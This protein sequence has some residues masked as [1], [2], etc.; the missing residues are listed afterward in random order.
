MNK[1]F[2]TCLLLL[3]LQLIALSSAAQDPCKVVGWATQNGGTTGGG[4][5]APIT[6]ATLADLQ[7][8]AKSAG[9]KVIYVSGNLG[10]G[11]STRV[12]VAANKTIIGLPGATLYGGFDVKANNVI[13]RNMIIHGPGSVDVNGVDCITVQGASNVWV[14][15]CDIYDGQDGNFDIVDGANYVTVT[16]CKFH[17]TSASVNHQFCNLLGNSDTKL[18][19]S[20]KIKVTM[21]YNWW[22]TGCV[23][24]MPRVRFGQVHVVNNYFNSKQASYCVRAGIKANILVEGNY[25]D[26]VSTP[27]DLYQN[28]FTAVTARN[29]YLNATTGNAAGSGTA[30][31]PP[32]ALTIAAAADVKGLVTA[33]CGA[34][35]TMPAP[36]SCA[37]GTIVTPTKFNLSTSILPA[38][39]GSITQSLSGSAFDSGTVL[40]LTATPAA[41]YTF[42]GWSGDVTGTINPINLNIN[43]NK[44]VT[45]N[46]QP[47]PTYTFTSA[48]APVNGGT[49]ATN[50]GQGPFNAG[51]VIT[52]TATP[53][54]G[55][56]FTGWTGNITS[57]SN[58]LVVTINANTTL[59]ANFQAIPA[60]NLTTS[61]NPSVGGTVLSSPSQTNYISG[62]VVT[63]T[64]QPAAGYI[65]TGWTGDAT[66][67][68]NPLSLS[69]TANKSV[70][71]NFQLNTG[72]TTTIR[73]ED[74]A[75]AVSGLCSYDGVIS[76][77]SGANNTKVI[78]L[79]NSSAKGITWKINAAVAG[80]YTFT[81][82]YTNGGSG[83]ATTAK[84]ILN[85]VT[86]NAAIAFPKT[87]GSTVFSTVVASLNL[88]QGANTIRLETTVSSAFADIDWLEVTG[89][90]PTAGNCL[91][92][93]YAVSA[94]KFEAI[95]T[96]TIFP[97]PAKNNCTLLMDLPQAANL[98]FK[99]TDQFGRI[100]AD[101]RIKYYTAGKQAIEFSLLRIP[102]GIYSVVIADEKEIRKTIKLVIE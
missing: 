14:D 9:A 39:S 54:A 2:T 7:T 55:Y 74:T 90:N 93:R 24:R 97:N 84:L 46:F 26:S 12:S 20:N 62:T 94:N 69:M 6:V 101:K 53:A 57:T 1:L 71:A 43:A 78:N 59:T 40:T 80:A 29:N 70:V 38:G 21:M 98:Q 27:I 32:Y 76:S 35:A 45:A 51:T 22:T 25:F 85:G 102:S 56:S 99:I 96:T 5:T 58:P 73:I 37:C 31:T 82:R 17:Y 52:V 18:S 13:I 77:N 79:T 8:Q 83:N 48:V 36:T 50:A 16:W 66:G 63:L 4:T 65:F 86:V 81:W 95:N 67:T 33:N 15:H 28:N 11:V 19:D 10:A 44:T 75:T 100:V 92:A 72:T 60:Y 23:E 42:S 3:C 41:G 91:A 64:A 87:S 88:L 34:G 47:I 61:A 30:F 68:T 49:V 89:I